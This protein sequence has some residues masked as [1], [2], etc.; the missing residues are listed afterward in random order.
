M[1]EIIRLLE[2]ADELF[3]EIDTGGEEAGALWKAGIDR[4]AAAIWICGRGE[5]EKSTD[6]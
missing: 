4:L 3:K 5:E 2:S 1:A 6:R